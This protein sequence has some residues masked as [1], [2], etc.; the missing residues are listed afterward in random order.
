MQ[1]MAPH[2][3]CVVVPSRSHAS[4]HVTRPI[5]TEERE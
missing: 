2:I 5:N 1:T 3:L 4:F